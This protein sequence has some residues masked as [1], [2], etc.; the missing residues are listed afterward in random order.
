[1]PLA[2]SLNDDRVEYWSFLPNTCAFFTHL[3][4]RSSLGF[5]DSD[6]GSAASPRKDLSKFN[7]A[8]CRCEI[9]NAAK[10]RRRSDGCTV[11][12]SPGSLS[13]GRW[14]PIRSSTGILRFDAVNGPP[15]LF[16]SLPPGS[17]RSSAQDSSS[18]AF[19]FRTYFAILTF[20]PLI[21]LWLRMSVVL[22]QLLCSD[23]NLKKWRSNS[24]TTTM[25]I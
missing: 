18:T 4:Y 20:L 17:I 16:C 8:F 3:F 11:H 6:F 9:S 7:S 22:T 23:R 2:N 25:R 12:P 15:R 21:R 1:M 14:K 13:D 24:I 19:Q 5:Q 10:S